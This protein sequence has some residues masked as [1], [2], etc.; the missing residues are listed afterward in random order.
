MVTMSMTLSP[1]WC[2]LWMCDSSKKLFFVNTIQ[3][4]LD[5][6]ETLSRWTQLLPFLL[7]IVVRLTYKLVNFLHAYLI[8]L[9]FNSEVHKSVYIKWA[10]VVRTRL[11]HMISS[12]TS[13]DRNQWVHVRQYMLFFFLFN[14]Q[15]DQVHLQSLCDQSRVTVVIIVSHMCRA[16]NSRQ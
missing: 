5:S 11:R 3:A 15:V 7:F 4:K 12:N 6:G 13:P 14:N 1:N 8:Q 16:Y 2:F 9:H 10:A